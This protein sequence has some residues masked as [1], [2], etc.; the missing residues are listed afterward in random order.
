MEYYTVI[1]DETLP[2]LTTWVDLEGII[3]NEINETEKDKYCRISHMGDIKTKINKCDHVKLLQSKVNYQ[4][5]EKRAHWREKVFTN[6]NSI[7]G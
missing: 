1:K 4:Q 2:F 3:L 5:N 6:D 7:R